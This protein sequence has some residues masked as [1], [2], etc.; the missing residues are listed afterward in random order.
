MR[1]PK[2]HPLSDMPLFETQRRLRG[3]DF[4]PG[5]RTLR[6]LAP[7][8]PR[9]APEHA[10]C[11]V[12]HSPWGHVVVTEIDP[13]TLNGYGW[14]CPS[15]FPA[16]AAWKDLGYLG[17]YEKRRGRPWEFWERDLHADD[18]NAA[19]AIAR[20]LQRY[21]PPAPPEH[22]ERPAPPVAPAPRTARPTAARVPRRSRG[23][24]S[25]RR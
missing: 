24:M 22:Q 25:A 16:G 21:A 12:Y 5:A 13:E 4:Y 8:D 6:A 2:F 20:I 3:H 23:V 14:T 11:V 9:P 17:E 18:R 10:R 19:A 1:L 15:D 7:R